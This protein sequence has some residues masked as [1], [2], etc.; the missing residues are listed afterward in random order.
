MNCMCITSKTL[1]ALCWALLCAQ[2]HAQVLRSAEHDP[3]EPVYGDVRPQP[4]TELQAKIKRMQEL[5]RELQQSELGPTE[6]QAA[7]DELI[8]DH[9]AILRQHATWIDWQQ[10]QTI[11]SASLLLEK[12][13]FEEAAAIAPTGQSREQ[14]LR[15]APQHLALDPNEPQASK[16]YEPPLLAPVN[17]P[18]EQARSTGQQTVEPSESVAPETGDAA[19]PS[20]AVTDKADTRDQQTTIDIGKTAHVSVLAD[21]QATSNLHDDDTVLRDI[22]NDRGELV[23]F[24]KMHL[25]AGGA[26][27]VDAY[28]GEGLFTYDEGGGS[29][30]KS[31]IRRAEGILRASLFENSEI[32]AQY[33]FD[34][35]IF[36]SVYWRYVFDSSARS[37]TVG[38]QKEPMG[39]DWL[40]GSKFTTALEP[41]APTSAFSSY[42]SMG[43]RYNGSTALA[44]KDNPFKLW[45]DSRTYLV[46]S[47][48][49]F[50]EDIENTNDTDKAVT[51]RISMGA[52]KSE[53][54]GYHLGVTA[55]YRDGEYDRIAPRPGLQ[56]VSRIVLAEPEADT[57]ALLGLEGMFTR[58]SLHSQWEVYYSDY[59]GG[60]VDAQGWGGYGQV[61]WLFNDKR[62]TY[63]PNWG[64]WA[65]IDAA[66]EHVFEVFG[67]VSLTHGD[68]DL[69]SSNELYLLTLGGN[70]YYRKF[71]VNANIILADTKRDL[72]NESNGHALGLRLQYLF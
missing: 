66:H 19:L 71:R 60:E 49:L 4:S 3:N 34:T 33:D 39:Q 69:S 58:D 36:R 32:K 41:S 11:D 9:D 46:T 30:S 51:G 37:V 55:S 5:V 70:W 72:S 6:K 67:R 64:L 31:Y 21:D 48:G 62:R 27:Q 1:F 43:I 15:N 23:L 10:P 54:S 56:D 40:L 28:Y 61:G 50:G 53:N 25:W 57:Q 44:S 42:R 24:G 65:P 35:D 47:I 16:I 13:I 18:G 68:D 22:K 7:L 14:V 12:M 17:P 63:R 52:N 20:P 8:R 59:S 38:N 29:D 26:V 2:L 45:G